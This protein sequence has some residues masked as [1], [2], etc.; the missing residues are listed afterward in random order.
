MGVGLKEEQQRARRR[1][2]AAAPF[3]GLFFP[4]V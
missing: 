1:A 2:E 4:V 3:A